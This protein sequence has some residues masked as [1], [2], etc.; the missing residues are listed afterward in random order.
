MAK[1]KRKNMLTRDQMKEFI[2]DNEIQT[3]EDIQRVL[4]DLF[5]ETLQGML[6]AE[7]DSHLGYEKNNELNKTTD[8][9][10]NGHSSK[11][12]RSDY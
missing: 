4:K 3:G 1:E 11:M 8:N 9:R 6:E 7:M 10:R 2:K 12:V 5:V